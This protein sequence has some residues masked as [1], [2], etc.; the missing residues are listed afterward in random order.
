MEPLMVLRDT[1]IGWVHSS[2]KRLKKNIKPIQSSL[3]KI[4]ALQGSTAT[5]NWKDG[6]WKQQIG[7]IAQD[8]INHIPEIVKK[9]DDG[10]YR[11]RMMPMEIFQTQ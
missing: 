11:E 10:Y 4:L 8:V 5:F 2:D 9:S 1:T 7:F 3:S 6:S